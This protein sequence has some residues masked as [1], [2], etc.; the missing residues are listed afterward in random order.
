MRPALRQRSKAGHIARLTTC[1]AAVL[2]LT[3]G[4]TT[5]RSNLGTTDSGCYLG[6]PTATKSVHS[7]GRLSGVHR[8]RLTQ[9]KKSFPALLD[10]LQVEAT[11]QQVCL[12]AFSG[13]FT[14]ASVS[15]PRGR[16]VGHLAVVVLS[17]PATGLIGTV[18]LNHLPLRFGHTHIGLL[19]EVKGGGGTAVR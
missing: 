11:S 17:T 5:V 9:L 18:I 12:F 4:C 19:A 14:T 6:L 1:V 13:S 3:S 2:M 8:L 10:D 7:A 15:K 16:P